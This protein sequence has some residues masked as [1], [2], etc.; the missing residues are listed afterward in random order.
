VKYVEW[1]QE[2]IQ[3]SPDDY[4][5]MAEMALIMTGESSAVPQDYRKAVAFYEYLMRKQPHDKN[6]PSFLRRA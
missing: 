3:D 4:D 1:L 6:W 5:A 2:R